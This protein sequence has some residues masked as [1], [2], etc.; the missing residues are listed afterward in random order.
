MRASGNRFL[1]DRWGSGVTSEAGFNPVSQYPYQPPQPPTSYGYGYYPQDPLEALLKPARRASVLMFI[2][3]GLLL[4][5]GALLPIASSKVDPSQ[6]PPQQAAQYQQMEQQLTNIG[7]SLTQFYAVV[8][9]CMS[10]PGVVL[11][12]LGAVVRRGGMGGVVTSILFCGLIGLGVGLMFLTLLAQ[13]GV[14]EAGIALIV[15]VGLIAA[16]VFLFQ[17]AGRA[18]QVSAY[19]GAGMVG[20][21]PQPYPQGYGQ[22]QQGPIYPS[23]QPQ[24]WQQPGVGPWGQGQA[25]WG[26]ANPPVPPPPPPPL[27]RE[28]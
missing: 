7:W 10:I 2:I 22:P 15:L 11:L 25:G 13:G 23:Q 27:D 3:G 24:T 6:L 4:P 14:V 16:L 12:I 28:G 9:A 8:G 17:A 20:A 5:C 26:Q 1:C 18:S 19:R 21:Y